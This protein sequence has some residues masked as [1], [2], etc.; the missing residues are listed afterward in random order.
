MNNLSHYCRFCYERFSW[1][2]DK[3]DELLLSV[4]KEYDR[5]E[6][7]IVNGLAFI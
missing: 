7:C 2:K 4:L 5:H 3:A 6:V 1:S